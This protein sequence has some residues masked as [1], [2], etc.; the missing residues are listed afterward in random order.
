[1]HYFYRRDKVAQKFSL[2]TSVI[3][4]KLP[5]VN[6]HPTC[7]NSPNLVTLIMSEVFNVLQEEANHKNHKTWF[8]CPN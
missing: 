4:K 1:M 2:H 7:L 8:K 6:N 3:L 5:K